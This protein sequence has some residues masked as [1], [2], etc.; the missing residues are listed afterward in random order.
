MDDGLYFLFKM[1]NILELN[2]RNQ[3]CICMFKENDENIFFFFFRI[4]SN[5]KELQ[6]FPNLNGTKSLEVLRLD[7]AQVTNVPKNLC[8]QCPK[9]K[10]L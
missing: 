10:S 1:E 9:L 8:E 7:R 4:L 5:L 6:I 3:H 2:Y